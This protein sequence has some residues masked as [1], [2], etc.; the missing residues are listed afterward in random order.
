MAPNPTWQPPQGLGLVTVADNDPRSTSRP[1]LD[2][3]LP[4]EF[5]TVKYTGVWQQCIGNGNHTGSGS[6]HI[7]YTRG[8]TACV[9]FESAHSL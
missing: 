3:Q 8:A 7:T 1:P 2:S 5:S 4:H 6:Y 9:S